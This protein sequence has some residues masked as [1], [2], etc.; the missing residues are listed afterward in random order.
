MNPRSNVSTTLTESG[1]GF[2][3][4]FQTGVYI[5]IYIYILSENTCNSNLCAQKLSIIRTCPGTIGFGL[6]KN[7]MNSSN[8]QMFANLKC[9]SKRK[10]RARPF[11]AGY[12]G[13]AYG[14]PPITME[15]AGC[16]LNNGVWTT[17]THT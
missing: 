15:A 7:L 6:V 2:G 13:G 8:H 12:T 4:H 11:G 10:R 1:I 17:N 9:Q 16:R 14:V 3:T 5:Y